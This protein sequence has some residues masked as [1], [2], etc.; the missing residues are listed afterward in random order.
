MGIELASDAV[1]GI[2]FN[3]R[4]PERNPLMIAVPLPEKG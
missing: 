1:G 4:A 2:F 3:F